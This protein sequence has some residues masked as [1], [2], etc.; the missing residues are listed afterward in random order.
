M[1]GKNELP[2]HK[3]KP[4]NAAKGTPWS[5]AI[6]R[7]L[8]QRKFDDNRSANALRRIADEVVD[9][10]LDKSSEHFEFAIKEIGSRIDGAAKR[11]EVPGGIDPA[12]L[13]LGISDAFVAL[14]NARTAIEVVNGET[15]MP[16]RSLLPSE[17][18]VEEGGHGEG[19]DLSKMSGCSGE[20]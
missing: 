8:K 11:N 18:C 15:I 17:V 1:T 12:E 6:R 5:K 14:S 4:S 9:C 16:D 2:S 13:L 7:A 3:N 19:V 20:S 10:A